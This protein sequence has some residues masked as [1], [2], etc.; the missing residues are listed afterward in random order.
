M[1]GHTHEAGNGLACSEAHSCRHLNAGCHAGALRHIKQVPHLRMHTGSRRLELSE[2]KGHTLCTALHNT[3]HQRKHERKGAANADAGEDAQHEQLPVAP[4][5]VCRQA[6]PLA[7][8]HM[9][10][11]MPVLGPS[12]VHAAC[13]AGNVHGS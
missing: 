10:N 5:K 3:A 13:M 11:R 8:P 7:C 2:E 9:P 6:G 12:C 4:H 1:W